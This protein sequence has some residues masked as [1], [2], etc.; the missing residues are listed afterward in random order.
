MQDRDAPKE[1]RARKGLGAAAGFLL[2]IILFAFVGY[3]LYY[4]V[5]PA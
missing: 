3:L 2:L 1:E 4:L 5:T